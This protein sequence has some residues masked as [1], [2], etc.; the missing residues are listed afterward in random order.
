M[1]KSTEAYKSDIGTLDMDTAARMG[2]SLYLRDISLLHESETLPIQV[3][4]SD[5]KASRLL[6]SFLQ[7]SPNTL[8]AYKAD[9]E[10]F[11]QWLKVPAFMYPFNNVFF[12]VPKPSSKSDEKAANGN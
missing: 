5:D 7:K 4:I 6:K 3:S 2:T 12:V 9:L 1:T 11:S 10:D 8:A